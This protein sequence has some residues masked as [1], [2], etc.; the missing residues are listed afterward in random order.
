MNSFY[1]QNI[2]N[3]RNKSIKNKSL[4]ANPTNNR[5]SNIGRKSKEDMSKIET[6]HEK[7]EYIQVHATTDRS[8]S[9]IVPESGFQKER[10]LLIEN[11]EPC[12]YL[13]N[14]KVLKGAKKLQD[15]SDGFGKLNLI[16]NAIQCVVLNSAIELEKVRKA[17]NELSLLFRIHE[18][19]VQYHT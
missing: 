14:M 1:D 11:E 18:N 17:A 3:S 12:P 15:F 8:A 19:K 9:N 16:K 2:D 5:N 10:D 6:S 7:C 4:I 13:Q